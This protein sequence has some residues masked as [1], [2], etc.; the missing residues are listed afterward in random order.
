MFV[1]YDH[2]KFMYIRILNASSRLTAP[3]YHFGVP[4]RKQHVVSTLKG[5]DFHVHDIQCKDGA[6]IRRTERFKLREVANIPAAIVSEE[7]GFAG[8]KKALGNHGDS[9]TLLYDVQLLNI[10]TPKSLKHSMSRGYLCTQVCANYFC[11]VR[12]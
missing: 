4:E 6:G 8:I 10:C 5:N 1:E 12:R 9:S 2:Q 3:K 7:L 11:F